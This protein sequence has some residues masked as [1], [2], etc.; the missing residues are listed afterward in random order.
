MGCAPSMQKLCEEAGLLYTTEHLCSIGVLYLA[1][2]LS[3]AVVD[4][5]SVF[6]Y[7]IFM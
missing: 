2:N 3:V 6:L 7:N 1:N 5:N 4:G